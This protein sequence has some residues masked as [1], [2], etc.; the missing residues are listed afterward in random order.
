MVQQVHGFALEEK[1]WRF[2]HE[3]SNIAAFS[4]KRR[5]ARFRSKTSEWSQEKK[6]Q[7][8][9]YDKSRRKPRSR[10]TKPLWNCD[11]ASSPKGELLGAMNCTNFLPKKLG[12]PLID[13]PISQWTWRWKLDRTTWGSRWQN[14]GRWK[15]SHG[16]W[17]PSLA[18]FWRANNLWYSGL[19]VKRNHFRKNSLC[20][21]RHCVC[22]NR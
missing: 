17:E 8:P 11:E 7:E 5:L 14:A 6:F 1:P 20:I 18:C 2:S 12:E 3:N 22:I 15:G 4:K 9:C 21:K 13:C 19:S 16:L 10:Y